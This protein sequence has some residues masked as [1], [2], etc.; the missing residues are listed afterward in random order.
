MPRGRYALAMSISGCLAIGIAILVALRLQS[1]A[2]TGAETRLAAV[3]V[4]FG[5]MLSFL[6]ILLHRAMGEGNWGHVVLGVSMARM[7]A[8]LGIGFMFELGGAGSTGAAL[9]KQPYWIAIGAGLLVMLVIETTVTVAMLA[10]ADRKRAAA[11]ALA[12]TA[13]DSTNLNTTGPAGAA[14]PSPDVSMLEHARS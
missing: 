14:K 3:A 8:V 4:A 12:G 7:L 5:A 1:P 10:A 6:P 11:K 13:G 9:E 2:S